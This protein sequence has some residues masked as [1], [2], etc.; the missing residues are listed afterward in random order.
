MK[1]KRPKCKTCRGL[2]QV[3]TYHPEDGD[4]TYSPCPD[5]GGTGNV[6]AATYRAQYVKNED[7]MAAVIAAGQRDIESQRLADVE[8][9]GAYALEGEPT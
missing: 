8:V 1:S 4:Y 2:K 9:Q 6:T 5:C 3:E 7:V